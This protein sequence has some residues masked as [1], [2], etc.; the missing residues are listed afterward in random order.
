MGPKNLLVKKK[1]VLKMVDFSQPVNYIIVD[2]VIF[3]T[4]Y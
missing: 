2:L 1:N 3:D 4:P